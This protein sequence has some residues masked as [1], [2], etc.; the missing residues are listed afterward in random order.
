M[1]DVMVM[2]EIE[3]KASRL[4]IDLSTINLDS[5]HLPPGDDDCGI[6]I[7]DEDIL[8]EENSGS[9]NTGNLGNII[10]VD[11]LPVVPKEKFEK[12]KGSVRK[13]YSQIGVMKDDGLWMPVDRATGQSLG[14]CFIEYNTSQEAELAKEKTHG[15]K[16]DRSHVLFA[17]SMFDDFDRAMNVPYEWAPPPYKEYTPREN[18]QQWLT[19]AKGRDQFVM[20]AG[21][22]IEVSWNDARRL[23]PDPVYKHG[24]WTESFVQWSPLGTY[25]ATVQRQGVVVWGGATTFNRLMH[26]A[27]PQVKLIDFS[28]GEKYLVTYSSH[29]PSNSR[30]ANRVVINIFDVRTGKLMRDFKG[31][32][33]DFS[34]GGTGGVMGMSWPVFKWSGGRDDKYFAR[35]RKN[36]LSV[37]DTET[38]SLVDKKSIK[39][40]N[41]ID[42]CWSPTD[43]IISLFVPETGGG[44]QPARVSLVQIPSKEELR[45]KN[46][47]S[48]SDCKMYWQS[49]GDYLAVIVDRYT[50]TKK[51]TCTGFELF[52]IK[53]RDIPIEVLE[54]ENKNDKIIAFAWEPKGH[55]FAV[56]HGYMPKPDISIYSMRTAQNTGRVSKLTTL[57]G[58]QANALFWSPVGRFIV[59][60]GLKGLNGLLEFYDV[61]DLETMANT[62]HFYAT[63]VEWDPTG[64][65]VATAVTHH[66]NMENGF[67]IWSFNGK[68]LYRISKDSLYQLLWRPRPA[69]FLTAEKEEE[70]AKNLKKYSKKYEAEDQDVSL[71]LSEQEQEKRKILKE[72]WEKWVNQWKQLHEEEMSKRQ[73]LINGKASDEEEEYEAKDIE[74]E[75]VVDVSKEILHFEYGQEL[76]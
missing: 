42:F 7:D 38:F 26:Y 39:V 3:D 28:P 15:Y 11:N 37:Y 31:S 75:E 65:Y 25:L 10:V 32:A 56:I 4:G 6:I 73:E 57:K 62:E 1:A 63:D 48:V 50:K 58:K 33:D 55:R 47:F 23:K 52:R 8:Q 68:H 14:Y 46:L 70:I 61:D 22:D 5:I 40:E 59:L 76:R 19:D 34:V 20:L 24:N 64:R 60:A 12:L 67:N 44:N 13:L 54:L 21:N 27:H 51:N 16:F 17:G 9:F 71:L 45:Q 49:N 43:P 36:V 53:E 41:I 2:K 29:E 74:V 30:D 66:D 69:S 18:L 72:D 35:M